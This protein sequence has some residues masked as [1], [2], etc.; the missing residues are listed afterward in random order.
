MQER[1]ET[2]REPLPELVFRT[3]DLVDTVS[4]CL[5][6]NTLIVTDAYN[7]PVVGELA[8]SVCVS[9]QEIERIDEV[10]S[11]VPYERVVAVGGC[12]ALDFGRAC[13]IGKPLVAI[14][15]ILSTSCLSTNCS[16]IKRGGMY[17]SERTQAPLQTLISV[18]T[19]V[20]NHADQV[21]KW[22]IS[23]L[24]DL[25]AS[26]SASIEYE[27]WRHGG[28]FPASMTEADVLRNIPTVTNAMEWVEGGLDR[29]DE[30]S[31][32]RLAVILHEASVDIIRFG[33][34]ALNA[35]SEHWL[36][37]KMQERRHY[38]KMVATHGKLVSIGTLISCRILSE[39][40]ANEGL[41]RRVRALH[42]KLGLPQRGADLA[43]LGVDV[44]H[45][46]T[47]LADLSG[48]ECLYRDYFT[49]GDF[50]IV[51]DVFG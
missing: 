34:A 3:D 44:A 13:A 24:G 11:G 41:Y 19:I 45:I 10:R 32:R 31:L 28:R 1:L 33:Q 25:F 42:E 40:T 4:S 16:V 30:A 51:D 50:S 17:R 26:I 7:C 27:Y 29:F 2:P 43:A 38:P 8:R 39:E 15:T 47:G 48:R 37:Y 46:K 14:P 49:A 36:Y 35:A 22:S 23:G 9:D 5:A 20:R 21:R 6:P 12:T 18:P